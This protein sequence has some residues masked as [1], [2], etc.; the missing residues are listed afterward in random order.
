LSQSGRCKDHHY[1]G[2]G[3]TAYNQID[4]EQYEHENSDPISVARHEHGIARENE[5]V[6]LI[7]D[8]Q[9]RNAED[10]VNPCWLPA[11]V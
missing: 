4:Q 9:E 7:N 8:Q 1:W 3:Y 6:D 5:V 10:R 2:K 11:Q